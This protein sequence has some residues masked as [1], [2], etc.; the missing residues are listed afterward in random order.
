MIAFVSVVYAQELVP[1]KNGL[2]SG[3]IVGL[4]FECDG[5][6]CCIR[7]DCRLDWIIEYNANCCFVTPFRATHFFLP[8]DQKVHELMEV[9][10]GCP[11]WIALFVIKHAKNLSVIIVLVK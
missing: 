10:L 1:G 9:N 4:A 6:L 7:N 11:F 3:L 8:S 5:W 2:V